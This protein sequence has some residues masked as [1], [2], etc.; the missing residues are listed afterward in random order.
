MSTATIQNVGPVKNLT[1]EVPENGGLLILRGKNGSGKSRSL[2]AIE[3]VLT[4]K[5]SLDVRDG[6]LNGKVDAFGVTITVGRNTRR[7]GEL[8]VEALSSKLNLSELIDPGLKTADAAD[9]KRIKALCSVAGAKADD[10]LFHALV[11]GKEVFEKIVS[12]AAVK[13]DDIVLMADRIKRDLEAE[14]RREEDSAEK[15]EGRALGAK[16]ATAGIDLKQPSD[17]S[18]LQTGLE[19]AIKHEA[20]LTAQHE[21]NLNAAKRAQE[22]SLMLSEA[23]A[24]Y[25]GQSVEECN[26]REQSAK[27][28]VEMATEKLRKAEQAWRDAK[29]VV[30]NS[31]NAYAQAIANRKNAEQYEAMVKQWREQIA[32]SI[33]PAPGEA[34]I[35]AAKAVVATA[36]QAVEQ[37][38]L[39]RNALIQVAAMNKAMEDSV[40]HRTRAGMLR[41]AAKGTDEVL[42]SVVGKLGTKL[43]VEAGRL[44]LD[45][46]RGATY[47]DDL[48]AGERAKIAIDIGIDAVGEHGVLTLSQEIYEGLDGNNRRMIAEHAEQ[49]GV[50]ILTAECS[51]DEEITAEVFE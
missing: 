26:A 51:N 37:G 2:E 23:E 46:H 40:I 43:R 48:S 12:V 36:R 13:S 30:E 25:T 3:S 39:I 31:N 24:K 5:G 11:G 33:P 34:A 10:S 1:L 21:A 49:R 8:E 16:N 15:A 27:T 38:A 50:L 14:A 20:E 7:K 9:A 4:G 47:Y 35:T 22:A 6:A 42:S 19:Q 17:A 32:A 45:T 28:Q 29:A 18:I 41:E 44:V